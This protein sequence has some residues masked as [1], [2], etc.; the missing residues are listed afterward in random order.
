MNKPVLSLLPL[1]TLIGSAGAQS[2]P[3]VFVTQVPPTGT[4]ETVTSVGNNHLPTVKAAPRGGDLMIRYSDGSIRFLTREA[5]FGTSA[6]PEQ[7]TGS[8][9]VRPYR[10]PPDRTRA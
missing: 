3:I 1:I 9:A 7:R 4:V 6:T 8:I 10:D 2:L 5:E